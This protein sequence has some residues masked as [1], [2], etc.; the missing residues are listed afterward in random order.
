MSFFTG[1]ILLSRVRLKYTKPLH[2][3]IDHHLFDGSFINF[4]KAHQNSIGIYYMTLHALVY[5][6]GFIEIYSQIF[7]PK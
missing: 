2:Y 4:I 3:Y 7:L 1:A 6:V 5:G